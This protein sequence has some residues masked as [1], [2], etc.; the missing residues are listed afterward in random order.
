[1]EPMPDP[2]VDRLC[3]SAG[4]FR[5][6]SKKD[7]DGQERPGHDGTDGRAKCGCALFVLRADPFEA[8]DLQRAAAGLFGDF[9][10]LLQDIAARRLVAVEAAEQFGRHAPVGPRGVPYNPPEL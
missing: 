3:N 8:L 4:F 1:M 9:A 6:S 2:G 7:V 10:A 5:S